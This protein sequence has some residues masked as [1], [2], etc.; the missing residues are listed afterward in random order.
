MQSK[1]MMRFVAAVLAGLIFSLAYVANTARAEE[2][3]ASKPVTKV[4]ALHAGLIEIMKG[5]SD[6]GLSGRLETISPIVEESFDVTTLGASSIGLSTWR[7]WEK[8]QKQAYIDAFRRFLTVNYAAQFKNYSGQ[9]FETVEVLDGP[10]RTKIVKT[11]LNRPNEDP[12]SLDYLVRKRVMRT[13]IVDVFL[14][15]SISEAARRRSEFT[16][17]YRD[18]GFDGLIASI[19]QLADD[20]INEAEETVKA[21]AQAMDTETSDDEDEGTVPELSTSEAEPEADPTE[22]A[23]E[24][25]TS[26]DPDGEAGPEEM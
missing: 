17:V 25:S 20:L 10:K 18:Q 9:S 23:E 5:G 4:E 1:I 12:V 7:K 8:D 15:G 2:D 13:R 21:G 26:D 19:N 16:S 24:A 14:D 22:L 3:D 11:V 6:M